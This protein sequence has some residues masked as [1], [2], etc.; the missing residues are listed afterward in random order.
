MNKVT[1]ALVTA[2]G[3]VIVAVI[4]GIYALEV[5]TQQAKLIAETAE[6]HRVSNAAINQANQ[7]SADSLGSLDNGQ[8]LC[9]VLHKGWAEGLIVPQ[10]WSIS[11]CVDYQKKTQ[12]TGY[13]LGCIYATGTNLGKTDGSIPYPSCGWS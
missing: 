1:A 6:A 3:S 10:S 8:K 4:S 11:L 9:R 12:G 2:I 13:Q 7:L 5:N